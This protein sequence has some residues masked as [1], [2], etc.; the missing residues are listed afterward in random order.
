MASTQAAD[1]F[2]SLKAEVEAAINDIVEGLPQLT[3]REVTEAMERIKW[4]IEM[5]EDSIDRVMS[6]PS[7]FGISG[8]E[9]ERR[10]IF[11]NSMK[12]KL[13]SIQSKD[14][15]RKSANVTGNG[16]ANSRS[17]ASDQR[18]A[19]LGN[20]DQEK[21]KQQAALEEDN[22]NFIENENLRRAL[23]MRE[24]DESL[25]DLSLAVTRI[26]QMGLTIHHE[27]K[28]QESLI[29]DLHERTDYS[30]NNM[31]DVNKLV[32]QHVRKCPMFFEY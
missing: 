13:S 14:S 7:K 5:M 29:D 22:E 30:V 16:I 28:E 1:P 27:L 31:S 26:G 10:R 21:A 25:D 24:Q 9:I 3:P 20:R 12:S 17:T 19:L 23:I 8:D 6:N 11:V 2:F 18:E 4:D 32:S 15:E